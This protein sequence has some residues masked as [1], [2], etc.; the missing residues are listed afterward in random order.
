MLADFASIAR[1][2]RHLAAQTASGDVEL[3]V[4]TTPERAA[5]VDVDKLEQMGGWQIVTIPRFETAAQGWAAG[6]RR[7]RSPL[8]VLCEDHSFPEPGWAEA[9]ISEHTGEWAAVAPIMN[10]G[11]PA[12][13]ISWANF[14]LCFLNWYRPEQ[15]GQVPGGPGH[16]T[17]YRLSAIAP[18]LDSLEVWFNP[19]AVLHLDMQSRGLKIFQSGLAATHHVNISL[20]G[21]F[22]AHSFC[23][24]RLFGGS[25]AAHWPRAKAW[26]YACAFPLVPLIR[27]RRI[28]AHLRTPERRRDAHFYRAL[29][30]IMAGLICHAAGEAAGYVMG[31]G[32]VM[33]KYMSFE[34]RRRDHLIPREISLLNEPDY[35]PSAPVQ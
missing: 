22:L 26:A 34:T 4:V 18:Y 33:A 10:N 35:L 25:R 13:N 11:N 21:S 6:F 5:E 31:A 12:T 24:G 27:L 29:P 9:L 7:A 3:V 8:A 2:V 14:L 16:N 19:E 15:S 20:A 1:T 23:G 30:W 17:C 28:G 32:D